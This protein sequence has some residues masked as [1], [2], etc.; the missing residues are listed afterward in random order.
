M[1]STITTKKIMHV[2]VKEFRA[3]MHGISEK[4]RKNK[5]KL[6]IMKK[7]VPV[8]EVRPLSPKEMF[9][10]EIL[11]AQKEMKEGKFYTTEE[12]LAHLALRRKSV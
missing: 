1:K 4:A 11:T 9:D 3:N 7:N 5:C 12:V 6:L 10:N 2:G 8:F